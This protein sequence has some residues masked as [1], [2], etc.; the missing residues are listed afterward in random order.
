MQE[1]SK[2][3]LKLEA[4]VANWASEPPHQNK[5]ASGATLIL[6]MIDVLKGDLRQDLAKDQIDKA[7]KA[8]WRE[9]L[10]AARL[11]VELA[12]KGVAHIPVDITWGELEEAAR[13][14]HLARPMIPPTEPDA[15][16]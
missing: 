2:E 1:I 4:D 13:K 8:L 14:L 7:I 16:G 6:R 9:D 3:R 15:A 12:L 10:E 11:H 5:R